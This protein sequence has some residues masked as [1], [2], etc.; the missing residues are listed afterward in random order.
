MIGA[1][2]WVTAPVIALLNTSGPLTKRMDADGAIAP[3]H[4]T[5]REDSA[6]SPTVGWQ[7]VQLRAG[8]GSPPTCVVVGTLVVMRPA[9]VRKA[10]TSAVLI[11]TCPITA[12]VCPAPV[13]PLVS[14]AFML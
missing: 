5:S 6:R 7:F 14:R 10:T 4:S 1:R 12:M 2:F 8:P 3:D 13:I 11:S 9:A